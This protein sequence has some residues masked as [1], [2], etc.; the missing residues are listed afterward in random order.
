V[1][2][3]PDRVRFD[4]TDAGKERGAEQVAPVRAAAVQ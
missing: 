3:E 4:V 2:L 1:E